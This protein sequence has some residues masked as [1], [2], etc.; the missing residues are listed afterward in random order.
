M[1]ELREIWIVRDG[2]VFV[3]GDA[4]VI[5]DV[6]A[7]SAEVARTPDGWTA[8]YHHRPTGKFWELSYPQSE[9]H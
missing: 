3:E 6:L 9:M 1:T 7:Q 4:E 8:L 5:G 2:N